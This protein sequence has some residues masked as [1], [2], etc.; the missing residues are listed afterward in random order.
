[1][2]GKIGAW[3]QLIEEHEQNEKVPNSVKCAVIQSKMLT[4]LRT[5]LLVSSPQDTDWP[6][7]RRR[8][9]SN[10][11]ASTTVPG[12]DPIDI[13]VCTARARTKVKARAKTS[14]Q[15]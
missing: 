9:E 15:E 14:L 4:T 5:R 12:G 11:L 13:G 2:L 10:L 8:I 6:A 7:M 3:E 1:M